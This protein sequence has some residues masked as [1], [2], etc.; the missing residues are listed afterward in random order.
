[1]VAVGATVGMGIAGV[2][3]IVA[4][5]CVALAVTIGG[6]VGAIGGG[7]SSSFLEQATRSAGTVASKST[8]QTRSE[9]RMGPKLSLQKAESHAFLEE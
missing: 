3:T 2:A 8:A 9:V 1:M 4:T 7:G 5:G 6:G